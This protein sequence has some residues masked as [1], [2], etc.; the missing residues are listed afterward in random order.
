MNLGPMGWMATSV[1]HD[2]RNPLGTICAG[3]E[4]LMESGSTTPQARRLVNNMHIAALRMRQL[5]SD[6]TAAAQGGTGN[7][8]TCELRDIVMSA[9]QAAMA[10]NHYANVRLN[11]SACNRIE[12]VATRSPMERVLFNL[13][14]NA[15]EAMTPGGGTIS[16]R[17]RTAANNIFVEVEDSG[18]GISAAIRDRLFEPFV[19]AGK[20]GGLGLGLALARQTILDH[21]GDMW[22]EPAKGARFVIRLPE[23]GRKAI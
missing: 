6:L 17:S 14:T 8:E 3:V 22:L 11:L 9:Y 19:T 23:K 10:C 4:M 20:R 7:Q 12:L 18:P 2:L 21:G 13:I 16:I 5:L 15:F 1:V